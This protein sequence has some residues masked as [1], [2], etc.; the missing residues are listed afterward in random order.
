VT[1]PLNLFSHYGQ[2]WPILQ[3]PLSIPNTHRKPGIGQLQHITET[4]FFSRVPFDVDE[5]RLLAAASPHS[6]QSG[7]WLQAPPITAVGLR[8]SDEVIRVAVAT[9]WVA[10]LVNYT[11]AHVESQWTLMGCMDYPAVEALPDNS[12]TVV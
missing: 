11:R 7:D 3:N 12:V 9:G 4:Y 10:K 5:A 8:L 1:N 2:T 6:G